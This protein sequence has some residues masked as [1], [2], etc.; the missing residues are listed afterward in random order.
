MLL[1][2]INPETFQKDIECVLFCISP[3][4]LQLIHSLE[5]ELLRYLRT[6][7]SVAKDLYSS[8]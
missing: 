8:S 1:V 2:F 5:I 4:S 6:I 7:N 3:C